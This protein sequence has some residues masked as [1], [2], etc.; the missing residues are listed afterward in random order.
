MD[1]ILQ[2]STCA[3]FQIPTATLENDFT[4]PLAFSVHYTNSSFTL[5]KYIRHSPSC[6]E[7]LPLPFTSWHLYYFSMYDVRYYTALLQLNSHLT[8]WF[9]LHDLLKKPLKNSSTWCQWISDSVQAMQAFCATLT[10]TCRNPTHSSVSGELHWIGGVTDN[11]QNYNKYFFCFIYLI[12][13]NGNT[14][15]HHCSSCCHC[16]YKWCIVEVHPCREIQVH[17]V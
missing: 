13:N 5:C 12:I 2:H 10:V 7:D 15:C 1:G 17:T 8:V 6:P 14:S 4:T 16:N 3:S 9:V 11:L